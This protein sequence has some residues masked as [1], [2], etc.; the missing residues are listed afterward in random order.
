MSAAEEA[1]FCD[2]PALMAWLRETE[3]R[4]WAE[5]GDLRGNTGNVNGTIGPKKLG[6]IIE[7]PREAA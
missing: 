3:P 1:E 4:L 6:Q 2:G 7:I 5:T